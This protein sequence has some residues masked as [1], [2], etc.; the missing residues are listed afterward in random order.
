MLF[1]EN[2]HTVLNGEVLPLIQKIY[3]LYPWTWS[4]IWE[5]N[6]QSLLK[7]LFILLVSII[8]LVSKVPFTLL[9]SIIAVLFH[10]Q[11]CCTY[12]FTAVCTLIT[13][14]LSQ[15]VHEVLN[16]L[17]N[18]LVTFDFDKVLCNTSYEATQRVVS[19]QMQK[20]FAVYCCYS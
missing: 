1:P 8:I 6:I 9:F 12:K 2:Y 17:V 14:A 15:F 20:L 13:L 18:T 4:K 11:K 3:I 19:A 16:N 5:Y 10:S 7:F